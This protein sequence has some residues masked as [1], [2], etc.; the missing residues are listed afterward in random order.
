MPSGKKRK[1]GL[2]YNDGVH[3]RVVQAIKLGATYDM[4]AKAGGVTSRTLRAWMADARRNGE[5][6][7]FFKLRGDVL[8]ADGASGINA[9]ACIQKAAKDGKWQAAAWLLERKFGYRRDG[10]KELQTHATVPGN[11]E[12][13]SL[14][15]LAETRRLRMAATADGSHVAAGNLLRMEADMVKAKRAEERAESERALSD[16]DRPALLAVIGDAASGLP[17]D[18]IDALQRMLTEEKQRRRTG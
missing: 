11:T 3:L 9:L 1:Y 13:H 12:A 17:L 15:L 18:D 14:E 5:G 6:S 7:P 10:V 4:A 2:K 8:A 16:A